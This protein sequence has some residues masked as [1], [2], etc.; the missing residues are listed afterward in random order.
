M[1]NLPVQ[2]P[3]FLFTY[4]NPFS[5]DASLV[6]NWFDYVKDVSLAKYTADSVGCY[7]GLVSGQ[8]IKA[9]HATGQ[10]ICGAFYEG[11]SGLQSQLSNVEGQLEQVSGQLYQ[12]SGQL[13]GVNQ[14][15]SLILDEVRTSNILQQ[16]IAE[17]LRIPDSQKQRQHHVELGLKFLKNALRDAD[18]Y[19]DAL[20][21]L[22]AAEKLMAS[23]YFVLHRIGLIYLYSP[24]LGD[25]EKAL[26]YFTRAAK[27]AAIE[28]D[29]G[30]S[31]LSNILGKKANTRFDQQPDPS[32]G[33][34]SALAAESYHH[35][36]TALYALGRFE[37]AA[38]M[39]E[40]AVKYHAKE[41][42]Y[43]FYL[44]KYQARNG[45]IDSAVA[46]LEKA[47]ELIPALALATIG[48]YDLNQ[49]QP[50]LEVLEKVNDNITAQLNAGIQRLEKWM[51]GNA[52]AAET[53]VPQVIANAK[54]IS[55]TGDY[56]Q[57]QGF[58]AKLFFYDDSM[59]SILPAYSKTMA[60]LDEAFI[61][62][63]RIKIHLAKSME[64]AK[65]NLKP[66]GHILLLGQSSSEARCIV[67]I[68]AHFFNRRRFYFDWPLAPTGGLAT[69]ALVRE[70]GRSENKAIDDYDEYLNNRTLADLHGWLD[71]IVLWNN[72]PNKRAEELELEESIQLAKFNKQ[73]LL[74]I[75]DE[76]SVD[77]SI[78]AKELEHHDDHLK[79]LE[80]QYR[81]LK[82]SRMTQETSSASVKDDSK[83][84]SEKYGVVLVW[85][86]D[87]LMSRTLRSHNDQNQSIQT[88]VSTICED[89]NKLNNMK[90]N[91]TVVC[92]AS[93][94]ACLPNELLSCFSIIEKLEQKIK[95]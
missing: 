27:Y 37:D 68:L 67:D 74:E 7:L 24:E 92:T 91:I 18:L 5:K 33:D 82:Y 65:L 56:T 83:I 62:Q 4:W 28:S 53:E 57:K 85:K 19:Q 32:A 8:Q 70:G 86:I 12:I 95:G 87:E 17:L 72:D 49:L 31:R 47:V 88:V 94:E 79:E 41:G 39:A 25:I 9:I 2:N 64:L 84:D 77:E 34:V 23:D 48:D 81:A 89:L 50:I 35:A 46:H 69:E 76:K 21:E 20:Q 93:S 26:D 61:G 43:H 22:L 40:K 90:P 80:T 11:M 42:K 14:R 15:L 73:R 66:L 78:R 38:K 3:P 13:Q 63:E 30:A 1:S 75:Y 52:Q 54:N 51:A 44:A 6:K 10:K 36:S 60:S 59:L 45:K 58:L 29:P 55:K 16:N 71:S